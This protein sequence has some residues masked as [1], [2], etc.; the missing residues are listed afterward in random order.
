MHASS[1]RAASPNLLRNGF[2][3]SIALGLLFNY[4]SQAARS[5][6][7]CY[8]VINKFAHVAFLIHP[9]ILSR[10]SEEKRQ[11]VLAPWKYISVLRHAVGTASV[12]RVASAVLRAAL[13]ILT[14]VAFV[15]YQ[16]SGT[17]LLEVE[18][19]ND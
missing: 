17:E 7:G 2:A 10:M 5:L 4:T 14:M 8:E 1:Y 6:G 11:R 15:L 19:D 13:Y 12:R 3:G 16:A 18:K 9:D